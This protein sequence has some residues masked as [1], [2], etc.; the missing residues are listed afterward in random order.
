M[1]RVTYYGELHLISKAILSSAIVFGTCLGLAAPAAADP[2]VF[3]VLSCGCADVAPADSP[4][5]TDRVNQGIRQ[6]LSSLPAA[7][8]FQ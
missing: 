5:R 7:S 6:G 1:L 8:P 2:S 3:G 4:V